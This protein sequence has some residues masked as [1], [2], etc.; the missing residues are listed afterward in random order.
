MSKTCCCNAYPFPHR[1]TGGKCDA[2]MPVTVKGKIFSAA[3]RLSCRFCGG[4]GVTAE[5]HPYGSTY[6]TEYLV[7]ECVME[8][9]P[10][11]YDYHCDVEVLNYEL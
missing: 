1:H 7:C 5:H 6:A 11:S 10:D 9:L 4:G 8:Q 3:P 2:P